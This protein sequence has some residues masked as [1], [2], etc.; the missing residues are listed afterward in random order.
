METLQR[1][2]D[3]LGHTIILITHETYTAEH[4]DRIIHIKD[5]QI[6]SDTNVVKRRKASDSFIK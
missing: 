1:L 6:E 2:H 3:E 4:A 5:G